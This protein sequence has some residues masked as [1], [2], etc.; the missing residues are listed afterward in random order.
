[1]KEYVQNGSQEAFKEIVRTHLPLVWS[2]ARRQVQDSHLAEDVAQ[3]VFSLLAQKAQTLSEDVI[4]SG[5]LYRATVHTASRIQRQEHRRVA[6]EQHAANLMSD[7]PQESAWSQIEPLLDSAMS[8]LDERDRDA[9]V[10]RYFEKKSLKDVGAALGINDDAAQKRLS[11]AVEK[12]R[13]YFAQNGQTISATTLTASLGVG[14]IQPAPAALLASI[15]ATA[16][17]SLPAASNLTLISWT[18]IKPVAATIALVGLVATAV[19]QRNTNQSLR[20][21][22]DESR[23]ALA[24]LNQTPPTNNSPHQPK[25]ADDTELL[26]LRAEVARLRAVATELEQMKIDYASYQEAAAR[27]L[28]QARQDQRPAPS[29]A[30]S[31]ITRAV[32]NMKQVGLAVRVIDDS[33]SEADFL[34]DGKAAPEV[35]K[36]YG[37]DIVAGK[38]FENIT[39]LVNNSAEVRQLAQEHPDPIIGYTTKAIQDDDGKWVRA[40]LFWDGSVTSRQHA[41]PEEIW[42]KVKR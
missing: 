34:I 42:D 9:I 28:Q 21:E 29:E 4:L 25:L 31:V 41:T 2:T 30:K 23:A 40:Y 18:M 24:E 14:A 5:W 37:S 3:Q 13:Q 11:R 20:A 35:I 6:R 33:K 10:L 15:T 27:A 17:S 32:S 38:I 1:M 8:E 22:L 7:S 36:I 16:V 39:M 12:L 26:R 19:V